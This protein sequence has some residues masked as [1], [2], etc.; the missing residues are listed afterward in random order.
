LRYG[1][2]VKTTSR[3]G[4]GK[5]VITLVP[6]GPAPFA[7]RSLESGAAR[8][9]SGDAPAA[10]PQRARA[11]VVAPAS[12]TPLAAA[13]VR[14]CA[15]ALGAPVIEPKDLRTTEVAPELLVAIGVDGSTEENAAM[16]NAGVIVAF[17]AN[18]S[19]PIV[20]I[21]DYVI[22]GDVAKNAQ[23]LLAAL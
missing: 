21:A 15:Q 12:L 2:I 17:V 14:G 22:P 13:A 10:P 8:E 20:Q 1:G 18:D 19:V 16:R 7:A 5:T 23:A 9:R 3:V 11:V 4:A 6:R